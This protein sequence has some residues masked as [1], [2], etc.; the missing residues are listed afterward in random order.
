MG[1]G[2]DHARFAHGVFRLTLVPSFASQQEADDWLDA[3]FLLHREVVQPEL[4]LQL[5]LDGDPLS[6]A[7]HRLG[8]G[9]H[10]YTPAATEA[11]EEKVALRVRNAMRGH[12]PEAPPRTFGVTAT[13]FQKGRARRD[14]DNMLKLLLDGIT[15]SGKKYG[16]GIWCDDSQVSEISSKLIR[17]SPQPRTHL[18]VYRTLDE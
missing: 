10:S 8:R 12:R 3:Q 1:H 2:H 14:V 15:M 9:G 18:R 17:A 11:A 16:F 4:M 5:W 13:F 7:R 6:K